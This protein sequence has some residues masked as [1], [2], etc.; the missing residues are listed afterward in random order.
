MYLSMNALAC[1]E[2]PRKSYLA[3]RGAMRW[4]GSCKAFRVTSGMFQLRY[5]L[6]NRKGLTCKCDLSRVSLLYVSRS[7]NTS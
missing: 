2:G 3:Q 7:G 1:G 4:C 5:D 6:D